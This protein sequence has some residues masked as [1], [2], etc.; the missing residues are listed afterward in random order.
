M[1]CSDSKCKGSC[2]YVQ[3]VWR[4]FI[5]SDGFDMGKWEYRY[6]CNKCGKWQ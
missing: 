1:T 4:P 3:W 2:S 5:S 6:K